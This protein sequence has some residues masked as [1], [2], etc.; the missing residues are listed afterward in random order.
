MCSSKGKGDPAAVGPVGGEGAG[1]SRR[2]ES[3]G[4]RPVPWG[5]APAGVA[6]GLSCIVCVALVVPIL[7]ESYLEPELVI[8]AIQRLIGLAWLQFRI[9]LCF[10]KSP[11]LLYFE[12]GFIYG[13]VLLPP[14]PPPTCAVNCKTRIT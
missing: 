6:G 4:R 7:S 11:D 8:P 9:T 10:E 14:M 2:R 5:W 3:A 1:R 13:H 12:V